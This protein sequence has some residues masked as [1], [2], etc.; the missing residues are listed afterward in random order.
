M[1]CAITR[2]CA[3]PAALLLAALAGPSAA[4]PADGPAAAPPRIAVPPFDFTDASAGRAPAGDGA[5]H[6]AGARPGG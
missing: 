2:A 3:I 1:I 5:L 4:G 6:P